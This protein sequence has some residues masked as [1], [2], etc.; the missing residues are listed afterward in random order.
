[1]LALALFGALLAVA[2]PASAVEPPQD[3][4]VHEAPVPVPEISF[5]DAD[6]QPKTL[7]DFH[8]KVLLLN[9]WATW[10][11]PCRKEMPTL[12]RL[13]AKLGG[14]DF[15]VIALSM[16]R[17]GPDI[18]KKFFAEIGVEHLALNIDTTGKAMFTL[19]ALGLPMT[20][21]IDREGKEI[22]RLIGPGEW[23]S[24][25]MM[26]FIRSHFGAN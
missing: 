3:F 23:D 12:D 7:A 14:P 24:P 1:M 22:G 6:G 17:G 15:E 20:L 13:Q 21:L 10:C 26:A 16:D 9:I 11:A 18:V 5:Q 8:G 25:E 2:Q 19:G 4:A